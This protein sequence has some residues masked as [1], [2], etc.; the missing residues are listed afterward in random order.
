MPEQALLELL[1]GGLDKSSQRKFQD[2]SGNY[3]DVSE[4]D[5]VGC[6]GE[7]KVLFIHWF[8]PAF[9]LRGTLSLEFIPRGVV[10]FV[11]EME[12][13]EFNEGTSI[14]IGGSLQTE[15]LP[16][17]LQK[18]QRNFL[19]MRGSVDMTSLPKALSNFDL[20]QNDFEL[21]PSCDLTVLPK[22]LVRFSVHRNAFTG[23]V[24]LSSLSENITDLTLSRSFFSGTLSFQNLPDSLAN[25]DVSS[26][27]FTGSFV[28]EHR[29]HD[30][31]F[32]DASRN[33]LSGTIVISRDVKSTLVFLDGNKIARVV[34]DT[35]IEHPMS[36]QFLK[37]IDK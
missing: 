24:C 31:G 13:A 15:K 10:E 25:V 22:K 36:E 33:Q 20:S 8:Y 1:I 3:L 37:S 17:T 30:P 19:S 29:L 4:W 35:G 6:I 16:S 9:I 21:L 28:L 26:N 14:P 11:I 5:G 18:F 27:N 23:S 12:S 32:F 34:D 7:D 2:A